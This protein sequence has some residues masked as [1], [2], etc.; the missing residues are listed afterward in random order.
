MCGIA[1]KRGNGGRRL[2]GLLFEVGPD[3][4]KLLQVC[5][6]P[7]DH[8]PVSDLHKSVLAFWEPA[9]KG[10]RKPVNQS[11]REKWLQERRI[12]QAVVNGINTYDLARVA[13]NIDET[14]TSVARVTLPGAVKISLPVILT[15]PFTKGEKPQLSL[16]PRKQITMEV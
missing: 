1:V 13:E 10:K 6:L 9:L 5:A 8:P 16:H 7:D 4:I 2:A 14:V 11:R 12:A 15:P 3:V